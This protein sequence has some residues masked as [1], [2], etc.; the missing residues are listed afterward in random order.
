M[1]DTV[2][3]AGSLHYDIVVETDHLPVID[4]TAVGTRWFPK[5]GGKGG[6][7]SVA[8]RGAGVPVR[9]LG[10]VGDDAF[11]AFLRARLT[12][13]GVDDRFVR[14]VATASGMSV[15][16]VL[17]NGGYAATIVSGANLTISADDLAR[18]E[19]WSGIGLVVLQNEMPPGANLAALREARRRRITTVLNAAP[20]RALAPELAGLVDILIVNAV[21]AEMMG[22]PAV[23]D[24]ATAAHAAKSLAQ[25]FA[26]VI[27]TAGAHGLSA[28]DTSGSTVEIAAEK[29][30][31]IS[32]HG[33]GDAFVGA[34]AASLITGHDL[35]TACHHAST[36]A[37]RHVSTAL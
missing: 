22:T 24:L 27:V 4:E 29:V 16:T 34:L 3:V 10:A 2:L 28:I 13:A 36:A 14:Q 11:G 8:A 5:F 35:A 15:A 26:R 12:E 21:E 9:M 30:K 31:V 33:A 1:A 7:Q 23:V 20:Y 37:A 32:T 25:R 18:D 17:P 19:V 6:N